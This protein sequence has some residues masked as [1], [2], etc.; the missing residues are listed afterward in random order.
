MLRWAERPVCRSA[1]AGAKLAAD[2][3]MQTA[4]LS[5]STR[6]NLTIAALGVVYGD[7]GTSPLYAVKQCF[8]DAT[9]I[10]IPRV[11]GVL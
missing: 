3:T 2:L 1:N 10:T 6:Q 4:A 7:I 8:H 5:T 11:F 9:A